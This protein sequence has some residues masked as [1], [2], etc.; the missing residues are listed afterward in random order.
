MVAQLVKIFPPYVETEGS[1]EPDTC[2]HNESYE[3][4]PQPH[5]YFLR[6]TLRSSSHLQL[7]LPSGLFP[8]CFRPIL[9]FGI[10]DVCY[11]CYIPCLLHLDFII[12]ILIII[13]I[14][15]IIIISTANNESSRYPVFTSL[16]LV[17]PYRVQISSQTPP[18]WGCAL[19]LEWHQTPLGDLPSLANSAVLT[20]C[21]SLT[22]DSNFSLQRAVKVAVLTATGRLWAK[23]YST[24]R[25]R[26][27]VLPWACLICFKAKPGK[28]VRQIVVPSS[29]RTTSNPTASPCA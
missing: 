13:I 9:S 7:G 12:I 26:V 3:S 10:S 24:N 22:T 16:L 11:V 5:T 6:Y 14:I 15:I 20:L 29:C 18:V 19:R 1:Q 27:R 21:S 28:Q 2:T 17:P 4:N 23:H 25:N 8:S